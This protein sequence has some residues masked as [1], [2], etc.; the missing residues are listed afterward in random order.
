MPSFTINHKETSSVDDQ[1]IQAGIKRLSAYRDSLIEIVDN[2]GYNEPESALNLPAD[3]DM[4]ENVVSTV[5]SLIEDTNPSVVVVVGMGG[6]ARG[7][8]AI[9]D[10]MADSLMT[11]FVMVDTIDPSC[12]SKAVDAVD[13][14]Q[15]PDDVAVCVVSKSG[16][17]TETIANAN[18]II[19]KLADR[20]S[21]DAVL[22]QTVAITNAGSQLDDLAETL[23]MPT[24]HIPEQVGGRFS[25][26]SAAGLVPLLLT[27]VNIRQLRDGAEDLK[28]ACLSGRPAS[29][30]AATLASIIDDHAQSS[31]RIINHFLFHHNGLSLGRWSA[32]LFAESLGKTRNRQ[33]EPVYAG[34]YPTVSIGPDDLHSLFQLQLGGP[35]NFFTIFVRETDTDRDDFT[36]KV[37][38]DFLVP[39]LK[40]LNG[41]SVGDIYD[42][43]A[44]ATMSTFKEAG[45]PFVEIAVPELNPYRIGQFIL[46]EELVVMYLGELLNVNAFNQ[47]QVETYKSTARSLLTDDN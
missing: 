18:I 26:L 4:L 47:P 5:Q 31:R 45:R 27:G 40:H 35:K 20:F 3:T 41:T 2:G 9:Y 14:A 36:H 30:P 28:E 25:V 23:G 19:N 12:V 21:R 24:A 13:I 1:S 15:N 33:G 8:Q 29:D 34:L 16:Q 6:S 22:D 43:L 38:S 42:A 17:T 39:D 32:Q 44:K 10:L 46:L 11:E 37:G 7:T